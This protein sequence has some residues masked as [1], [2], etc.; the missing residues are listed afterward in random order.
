MKRILCGDL[1][2]GCN[3]KA[4]AES[5]AEVLR[6]LSEHVRSVHDIDFNPGFLER[7]RE[8]IQDVKPPIAGRHAQVAP[9]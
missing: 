3:F 5:E 9:R 8:R 4:Q 2:P 1:V 7:A 6:V